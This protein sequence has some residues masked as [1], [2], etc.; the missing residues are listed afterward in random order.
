MKGCPGTHFVK[1]ASGEIKCLSKSNMLP[2][3]DSLKP[4]SVA[5]ATNMIRVHGQRHNS[6]KSMMNISIMSERSHCRW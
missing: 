2:D 6:M 3:G 1:A 4:N 5:I